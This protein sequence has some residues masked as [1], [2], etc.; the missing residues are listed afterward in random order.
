MCLGIIGVPFTALVWQLKEVDAT[1]VMALTYLVEAKEAQVP[2][3]SQG[4]DPWASSDLSSH[5]QTDLNNLQ[6][7][8]ENHLGASSL[9]REKN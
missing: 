5:L 3:N 8:G 1:D 6:R 2:H 9:Q 4:T 7:I